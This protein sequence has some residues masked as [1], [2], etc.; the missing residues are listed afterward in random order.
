ML[1]QN[2][3]CI[4]NIKY[5]DRNWFTVW[6]KSLNKWDEARLRFVSIILL[7]LFLILNS[8]DP[9]M[10]RIVMHFEAFLSLWSGI[11]IRPFMKNQ[12]RSSKTNIYMTI[13]DINFLLKQF[14]L[15]FSILS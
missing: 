3:R 1:V 8:D 7:N 10:K 9:Q 14:K 13:N 4:C 5:N 15:P 6:L 2:Y 11:V 12:L